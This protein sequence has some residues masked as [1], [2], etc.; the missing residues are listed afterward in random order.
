M[1]SNNTYAMKKFKSTYGCRCNIC[2]RELGLGEI[3]DIE[4]IQTK[5]K[6]DI[7]FHTKCYIKEVKE[8]R[9]N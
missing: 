7:F 8:Q 6:E 4:Y 9:G 1:I 3:D 5:R 2:N